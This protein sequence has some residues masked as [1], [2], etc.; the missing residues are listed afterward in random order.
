MI[1]LDNTIKTGILNEYNIDNNKQTLSFTANHEEL[2]IIVTIPHNVFEWYVDVFDR[3]GQKVH[4]NWFDYYDDIPANLRAEMKKSVEEFILVVTKYPL[5]LIEGRKPKQ[6][7]LQIYRNE[8]WT[9]LI[10]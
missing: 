3:N 6:S 8:T 1:E 10:Y 2:K 4:S 7:T 5:R 9:D